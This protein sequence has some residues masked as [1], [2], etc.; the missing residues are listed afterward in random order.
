MRIK[1]IIPISGTIDGQEWPDRGG[2]IDV[3]ANVADDMIAN[4]FA[5][6]CDDEPLKVET[7][8]RDIVTET[9]TIKTAKPRKN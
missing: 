2:V 6:A 5:S 9:A 8:S 1:M 7:A 4:G 3:A